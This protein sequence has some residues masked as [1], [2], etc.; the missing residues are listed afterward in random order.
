MKKFDNKRP[1][2]RG[3]A[4]LVNWLL[5]EVEVLI[6]LAELQHQTNLVYVTRRSHCLIPLIYRY[7][8]I[9]LNPQ[10]LDSIV[11]VLPSLNHSIINLLII[12]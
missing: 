7:T 2:H 6:S 9:R 4:V 11:C 1:I 3:D 8:L 10:A 12:S 5:L